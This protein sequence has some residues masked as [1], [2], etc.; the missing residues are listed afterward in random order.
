MPTIRIVPL[1]IEAIHIRSDHP[2]LAIRFKIGKGHAYWAPSTL[3]DGTL[4]NGD[5]AYEDLIND[6]DDGVYQNFI[7][8]I[9]ADA[10]SL[11]LATKPVFKANNKAT[12]NWED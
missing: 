5:D 2:E 3:T 1:S 6:M 9:S 4:F 10:R 7:E 12:Y 8:V 11:L